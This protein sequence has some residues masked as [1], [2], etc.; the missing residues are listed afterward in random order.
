MKK[1]FLIQRVGLI[2]SLALLSACTSA[3]TMQT[4]NEFKAVEN[5]AR[6]LLIEPDVELSFLKAAGVREVRADWTRQG[7]ENI[8]AS[9]RD[10]LAGNEHELVN[11]PLDTNNAREVQLV[12]L[13]E[14]VG[15]TILSH[16][17]IGVPLPSKE[18]KFD[19]SLGPGVRDMAPEANA[20]YALFLFARGQY[21]S[22]GRQAMAVGLAVVGLGTV[23]TGGQ[24]AYASLVDMVSGDIVWFNLASTGSGTDMRKPEGAAELVKVILKDV[25]LTDA[26][27]GA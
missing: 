5:K 21:A 13:H 7:K 15:A 10:A 19:W 22:S 9:I 18:D 25:P 12:K 3:R 2:V 24:A 26:K 14:A 1:G 11:H 27:E 23:S 8:L 4:T 16:R 17:F 20:D 6:I